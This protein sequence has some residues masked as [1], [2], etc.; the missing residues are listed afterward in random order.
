MT[1]KK[2]LL[3]SLVYYG[4]GLAL[5][6]ISY[7]KIRP[8]HGPGLHHI[9]LVLTFVGGFLWMLA[10]ISE[11]QDVKKT[12]DLNAVIITNLLMTL[13]F[14]I[15]LIYFF[16]KDNYRENESKD[17]AMKVKVQKVGD[18]TT[19]FHG[20]SIVFIKVKDSVLLNFIDSSKM[21]WSKVEFEK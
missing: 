5:A 10:A 6:G 14:A 4:I 16:N 11:Y 18:T 21:D 13:S 8:G 3:K 12:R 20:G 15:F 17:E 9:I 19:M 7:L 1:M 2:G